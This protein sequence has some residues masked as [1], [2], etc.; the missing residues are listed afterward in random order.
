MSI[1]EIT[2]DTMLIMSNYAIQWHI[3]DGQKFAINAVSGELAKQHNIVY[4]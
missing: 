2:L 1:A 3:R 4:K